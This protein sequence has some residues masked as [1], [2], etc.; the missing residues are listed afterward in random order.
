[1]TLTVKQAR[2][3]A[4]EKHK[5]QKD[6]GGRPY[7]EHLE[8][9]RLGVQV[10]GGG[11]DAEI[12]AL[13]HDII[14]DYSYTKVTKKMLVEIGT[15]EE[16]LKIIE[17]VSKKS[18][19]EQ[20]K[21]LAR[22]IAAG[23][24]AMRVKLA[25]L[26]HNTRHDRIA[27]LPEATQERLL[28]KYRPSMLRLMLELGMVVTQADQDALA[29]KPKGSATGQHWESYGGYKD[30]DGYSNFAPSG[31]INGDW[32]KG[33]NA[34]VIR[35]EDHLGGFVYLLAD[36][37]IRRIRAESTKTQL[38]VQ[39]ES[40]WKNNT[41]NAKWAQKVLDTRHNAL[42]ATKAIQTW[43]AAE[44]V[45]TEAALAAHKGKKPGSVPPAPDNLPVKP[46]QVAG[47]GGRA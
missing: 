42:E 19:E 5:T 40:T 38:K 37:S 39:V 34:P 26:M 1:M 14:E 20:G 16:T 32:P 41:K 17:A 12:A 27:E 15:S 9:V 31:L 46:H 10:L 3:F 8:A 43:K 11:T 45:R 4:F 7:R 29:T 13:F 18:G 33:W 6:K 35:R 24:G 47:S 36:G 23:P 21:Y 25:D 22:I 28:L 30:K 2:K 44:K